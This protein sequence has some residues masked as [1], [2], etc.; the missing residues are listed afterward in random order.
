MKRRHV[1]E[2]LSPCAVCGCRGIPLSPRNVQCANTLEWWIALIAA[3]IFP[4]EFANIFHFVMR[5]AVPQIPVA[6][7]VLPEF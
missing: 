3:G 6:S 2:L 5:V 7:C 1:S 4:K